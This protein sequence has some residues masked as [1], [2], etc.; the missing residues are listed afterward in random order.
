VTSELARFD[1]DIVQ[2]DDMVSVYDYPVTWEMRE[3]F[4]EALL[5]LVSSV[6]STGPRDSGI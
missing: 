6:V 4:R 3:Q 1:S 2:Q 5:G